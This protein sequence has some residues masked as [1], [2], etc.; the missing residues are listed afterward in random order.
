ME[1]K[2]RNSV[3]SNVM[4]T[5]STNKDVHATFGRISP[6]KDVNIP[7]G[8][9]AKVNRDYTMKE[10]EKLHNK[11][12]FLDDKGSKAYERLRKEVS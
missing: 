2:N 6:D 3:V 4:S 7:V 12:P 8:S 10:E 9:L 11:Y 1:S 5:P